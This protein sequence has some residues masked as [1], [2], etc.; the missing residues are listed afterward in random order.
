MYTCL[1]IFTCKGL[2]ARVSYIEIQWG[3]TPPCIPDVLVTDKFFF[4]QEHVHIFTETDL[5]VQYAQH[6][7][8]YV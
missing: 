5:H 6:K 7:Y 8:F 1:P 3:K 4:K 2:T